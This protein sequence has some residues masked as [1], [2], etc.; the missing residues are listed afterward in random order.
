MVT[1]IWT[2]LAIEDLTQIHAYISRD[3]KIYAD[4]FIDKLIK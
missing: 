4:R 2:E 1:I 3:S